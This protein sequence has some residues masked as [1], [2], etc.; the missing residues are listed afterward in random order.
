MPIMIFMIRFF[1]SYLLPVRFISVSK[2]LLKIFRLTLFAM[3]IFF[4]GSCEEGPTKIG[5]GLLPENDFIIVKSIDTLSALS[6]TLYD[7]SVRSD[8]PVISHLGQIYDPYFGT[9]TA[10]FVT[11]LRVGSEWINSKV[12][13]DSV[14]LYLHLTDVKG[15]S[16]TIHTLQLAEIAEQ[17]Y[18]DSAYYSDKKIPLTG[19]KLTNIVLP[20]LKPDT[21]NDIAITIPP[22]FGDFL[23]KDPSKFFY[24]NSIYDYRSF[25]KGIQFSLTS[26]SDPMLISL[27]IA[28]PSTFG[29]YRNYFVIFMHDDSFVQRQF[30]F[31]LDAMNK[32]AS[33]NMFSHDFNT[34]LPEFKIKHVNDLVYRDTMSYMQYL[35]GVY[36]RIELPGLKRIKEDPSFDNI[37]VNKAKLIVPVYFDNN[38]YKPSTVPS[39]LLLIYKNKDGYKDVVPDYKIDEGSKFFDGKI[40]S[41]ANVYN[42][43]IASFIQLYLNDV[44]NVLKPELEIYLPTG[45]AR[46]VI[47]KANKSK[48][49]V[50][51]EFRYSRF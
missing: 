30:Y 21:V 8:N 14:K 37:A 18:K 22:E 39:Q 17:I 26:S 40:D 41:T 43:N 10:G 16:N 4:V 28:P 11:Q 9:T 12:A 29:D 48:T 34:A 50:K 15:G 47:L 23:T 1:H 19:F 51:F 38:L 36:T 31:I 35:N 24:D 46:N 7:K 33:F 44:N 13:I 45:L 5:S 42:F 25:M 3:V 32:N 27:S 2:Y 6:Y 20:K 49:P